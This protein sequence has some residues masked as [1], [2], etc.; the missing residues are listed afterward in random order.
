MAKNW[1]KLR[2]SPT[3]A[4]EALNI[5]RNG[6]LS[7]E[8]ICI[9]PEDLERAMPLLSLNGVSTSF[10]LVK[11]EFCTLVRDERVMSDE[12]LKTLAHLTA[13]R[14][15]SIDDP[16]ELRA[17]L[18]KA[19]TATAIALQ[20]AWHLKWRNECMRPGD[21]SDV[22]LRFEL[23]AQQFKLVDSA[24]YD[25]INFGGAASASV[26]AVIYDDRQLC[27]TVTKTGSLVVD[28][29]PVHCAP[30]SEISVS[31]FARAHNV[32]I[33]LGKTKKIAVSDDEP[34]VGMRSGPN[35]AIGPLELFDVE[36]KA[37]GSI[38]GSMKWVRET[39]I[40]DSK[41]NDGFCSF[42]TY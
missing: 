16:E 26:F 9:V 27:K 12:A 23:S 6:R 14:G 24:F 18:D 5:E 28:F 34:E 29:P 10:C 19:A 31:L 15:G 40:E 1:E 32:D 30:N 20:R 25:P 37:A 39:D 4:F 8:E 2:A 35:V 36:G 42:C 11:D 41:N 22:V 7:L 38:V 13:L 17:Q 3:L 21:D 33:F